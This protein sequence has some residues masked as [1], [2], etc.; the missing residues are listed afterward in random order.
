MSTNLMVGHWLYFMMLLTIERKAKNDGI[1]LKPIR[2][3]DPSC[4]R[5]R[6]NP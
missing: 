3:H 4:L 1:P 2:G 5:P 6:L